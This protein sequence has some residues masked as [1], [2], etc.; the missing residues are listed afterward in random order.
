MPGIDET[1][2][3]YRYRQFDPSECE[4]GTVRTIKLTDGV[5]AVVCRRKSTSQKDIERMALDMA[6]KAEEWKQF[7]RMRERCYDRAAKLTE[8]RFYDERGVV[9]RAILGTHNP[10][11]V[12]NAIERAIQGQADEWVDLLTKITLMVGDEFAQRTYNRIKGAKPSEAKAEKPP[13]LITERVDWLDSLTR[14]IKDNSAT[15]VQGITKATMRQIRVALDEGIAEG[16][17]IP[18]LAERIDALYLEEIIPNR[19]VVIARTET[20]R[21]SNLGSQE[22][23][24]ASG[25]PLKKSWLATAD[26]RTRP[27]HDN[28]GMTD[29]IPLDQPYRT[30]GPDFPGE[31]LMFPGDVSLGASPGNTIQCRCTETYG[32]E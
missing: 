30:E 1:E 23:A 31:K 28:M 22:G 29:A 2:S 8:D 25:L 5:S 12:D 24:I 18:H 32:V 16:E 6:A 14:Y 27:D 15:L 11:D 20:I 9:K 13:A 7:D 21:A 3:S 26:D 4:P 10:T 17:S 19:S